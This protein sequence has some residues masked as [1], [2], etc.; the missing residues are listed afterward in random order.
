MF[1]FSTNDILLVLSINATCFFVFGMGTTE[2]LLKISKYILFTDILFYK[3]GYTISSSGS[4]FLYK[5]TCYLYF[6]FCILFLT[7]S[8]ANLNQKKK[9]KKLMEKSK[10]PLTPN[11]KVQLKK[12]N[13][14][15]GDH[16]KTQN[17][18]GTTRMKTMKEEFI[19]KRRDS[20]PIKTNVDENKSNFHNLSKRKQLLSQHKSINCHPSCI[21]ITNIGYVDIRCSAGCS[22][23]FHI[24]CW[25]VCILNQVHG[26]M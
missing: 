21:N 14:V 10:T 24:Q 16:F 19:T 20:V 7:Y 12:K 3:W 6:D 23:Q 1:Q 13:K 8:I 5:W 26:Y 2:I 22:F 18:S 9:M 17:E 15:K 25:K 4:N 11:K